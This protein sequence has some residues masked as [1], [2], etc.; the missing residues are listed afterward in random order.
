ML[1]LLE[2]DCGCRTTANQ[3]RKL[4]KIGRSGRHLIKTDGSLRC[5]SIVTVICNGKKFYMLEFDTSDD[6]KSL[7][8][9]LF[10][11]NNTTNWGEQL[12]E[13][14]Q[15]LMRGSLSWPTAF[16]DF[17]FGVKGHKS[18]FYPQTSSENKGLLEPESINKWTQ[19]VESWM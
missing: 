14:E 11:V 2:S 17:I 19:R 5:L 1:E 9:K 6:S 12:I 13:L 18:I 8:T 10:A 16:L 4:P 7:S 3:I 15:K